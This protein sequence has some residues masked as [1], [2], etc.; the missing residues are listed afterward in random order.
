VASDSSLNGFGLDA[1]SREAL[2]APPAVSPLSGIHASFN[3]RLASSSP[4]K[5]LA[6]TGGTPAPAPMRDIGDIG[7]TGDSAARSTAAAVAAAEAPPAPTGST[8][9][10]KAGVELKGVS[11]S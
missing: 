6:A 10:A 11:W 8:L 7:G 5:S 4:A 1:A 2:V 9:R 3:T